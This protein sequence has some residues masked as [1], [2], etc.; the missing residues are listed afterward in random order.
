MLIP[1]KLDDQRFE[2]IVQQAVGRLPWLCP[3]WTDHNAHDPGITI[4][5]LMAWYK[6]MLQ[7]EM[8]QLTPALKRGLLRLAGVTPAPP[9]A[10]ICALELPPDA[11]PRPMLSRLSNRL[12][13]GFELLEPVPSRTLTLTH[14]CVVRNDRITDLQDLLTGN[15]E[16]RPFFLDDKP[17]SSLRLGFTGQPDPF[18][19]LWFEVGQPH[20]AARNAFAPGQSDPREITWS[21]AGAGAMPPA[22]DQTHALSQSGFVGLNVPNGWTPDANGAYWLDL[23]LTRAGCEEQPRLR[24]V[25]DRRYQAAQQQTRARSL[26]FTVPARENQTIKL[27]DALSQI[28]EYAVFVRTAQ[29]WQQRLIDQQM[30]IDDGSQVL[31][32]DTRDIE[33]DGDGNLLVVCLDPLRVHDLLFDIVGRPGEELCLNLDGQRALPQ[34]FRLLCHTLYPDG[35]VQPAVWHLVD[36]LYTCGPRD[37]VFTYDPARETVQF[38]NGQYGA[39]VVPGKGVVMV[40]DLTVSLCS[41]GNIPANAGLSFAQDGE[42]V[43]NTA[44][45]GGRDAESL[46]EAEERLLRQMQHTVKCLSAADYERQARATPGLRVQKAKAL[47]GYD[48]SQPTGRRGQAVV[49][50]VVCPASDDRCPRPDTRFLDAVARQLERCRTIGIRT[51]VIGPRYAEV[52]VTAVLRVTAQAQSR[53]LTEVLHKQL[54]AQRSEIGA[55][56]CRSAIASLLQKQPG[57]LEL[58]RLDLQGMGQE[59]YRTPAGDLYLPPDTIAV[60]QTA[61]IELIRM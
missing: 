11:T 50:V 6:E 20:G 25:S 22:F 49:T 29:G 26:Y 61:K 13:V 44:A 21:F 60:L 8:D 52:I 7:Y 15:T 43:G 1:R 35:T 32:L 40:M 57:V 39:M 16:L 18:L 23:T 19:R 12:G 30:Q 5:E 17:G 45:S 28:A 34:N 14:A 58:R 55:P 31:T 4:L 59:V 33:Q 27:T 54:S 51:L 37:R 47:P 41:A 2:D 24:A 9:Q 10:A 42:T 38:G 48:R 56:V 36:D 46:S 3:A 53:Q